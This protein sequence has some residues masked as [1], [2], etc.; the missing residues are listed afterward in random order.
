M[1]AHPVVHLRHATMAKNAPGW[2]ETKDPVQK[3]DRR[4]MLAAGRMQLALLLSHGCE[5]DKNKGR[6]LVAPIALLLTVE[7]AHQFEIMGNRRWA[8]MPL[9]GVP[10]IGDCFADFR[11][12]TSVDAASVRAEDRVA[13]MT[14]DARHHL[15]AR[16]VGFLT[17]LALPRSAS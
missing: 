15:M 12:A 14:D 2:A 3:G 6:M 8:Q 1:L 11:S 16:L 4:H 10:D 5:I 9:P 17:R 13:M 7:P